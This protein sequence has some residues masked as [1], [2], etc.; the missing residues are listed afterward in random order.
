MKRA[1]YDFI[2]ENPNSTIHKC[3]EAL[4]IDDLAA[5]V[6]IHALTAEGVVKTMV[7]DQTG[8]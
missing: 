1:V 3:A 5:M 8:S 4:K 7:L 2:A 6:W